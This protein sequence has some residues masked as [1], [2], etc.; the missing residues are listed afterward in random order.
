MAFTEWTAVRF[1][2]GKNGSKKTKQKTNSTQFSGRN[3]RELV[4]P[5]LAE[6]C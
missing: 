2:S 6:F 4:F 5:L 3:T 1:M